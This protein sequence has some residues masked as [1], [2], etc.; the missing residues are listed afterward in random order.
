MVKNCYQI[1]PTEELLKYLEEKHKRDYFSMDY[2]LQTNYGSIYELDNDE[3]V[4]L[5]NHLKHSGILFKTKICFADTIQSDK[6]PIENPD[7]SIFEDETDRIIEIQLNI[8][9]YQNHLNKVFK[10]NFTE[11]N[12]EAILAYLKKIVGREIRGINTDRDIVGM[13]A[14]TGDLVK[15][16]LDC[17]WFIEKWY[18]M[19]NPYYEL[20]LL[21][22]DNKVIKISD[23]ILG[24]LKWKIAK[25][26][27]IFKSP[28][29]IRVNGGIDYDNYS[30]QRNCIILE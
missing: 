21:S 9:F 8:L 22:S 30:Q 18:G 12:R 20:N 2:Q 13:I 25:L 1:K 15:R 10:L 28:L 26:D 19:Y 5:P 16:E 24:K 7:K 17:K 29:I 11:I 23:I 4:F 3:I 27:S 14:V 6:F